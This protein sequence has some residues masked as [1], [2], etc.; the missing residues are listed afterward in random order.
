MKTARATLLAALILASVTAL[1]AQQ[2]QPGPQPG[3]P[4]GRDPLM[5]SL[6]P[7]ELIMQNQEAIGLSE[8]QRTFM[9]GEMQRTQSQVAG[10]QW[11]LQSAVERLGAIVRND[12]PDEAQT[13]TQLD[14]VL[15]LEREMKRAQIGLLVRLKGRLTPEQQATLRQRMPQGPPGPREER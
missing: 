14:T 2:P 7:P 4:G 9:I 10:T 3:G 12:R 15:S 13:L 11:R 8:E 6:F 5:G 1:G